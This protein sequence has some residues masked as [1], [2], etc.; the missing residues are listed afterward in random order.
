M[1]RT[2]KDNPPIKMPKGKIGR[3]VYVGGQVAAGIAAARE[4]RSARVKGDRL[5]FAHGML[6][7]AVLAVTAVIAVR[8]ARSGDEVATPGEAAQSLESEPFMLTSGR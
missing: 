4:I 1:S 2:K 3:M 5:V 7:A 6:T 8:T